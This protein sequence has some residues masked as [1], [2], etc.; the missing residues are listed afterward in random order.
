MSDSLEKFWKEF[1]KH[2]E[3]ASNSGLPTIFRGVSKKKYKLIP[4]IGRDTEN[5]T[6][7]DINTLENNL[8]TEF[9][10]LSIPELKNVP[11]LDIEWLFLAQHYGLPTRLLDWS[12]NPMVG[13]FF[14]VCGNDDIDGALYIA[15]HQVTDQYERYDYK[16]ADITEEERKIPIS[17]VFG[18]PDQGTVIFSRPKYTDQR[19]INQK[20]VFSCPADPFKPL[21]IEHCI[22]LII[23]HEH[24]IDIRNML[25]TMGI[26]HSYI[27]PGLGGI[28]KEI[29]SQEFTPITT[30]KTKIISIK[31]ELAMPSN[32]K[33]T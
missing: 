11:K 20:S 30:G 26:S 15:K 12:S 9:K 19:Y 28:A 33:N 8:I 10:R 22:K 24:K 32:I 18:I 23:K 25:K 21:E 6:H 13:L 16:T 14:A 31:M 29:K 17:Q 2:T 7:G 27:Y 3:G 1:Y 5:G 4:S